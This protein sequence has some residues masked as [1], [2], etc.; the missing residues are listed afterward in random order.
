MITDSKPMH[1]IVQGVQCDQIVKGEKSW[2][3]LQYLVILKSVV[4]NNMFI[5]Q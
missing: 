5:I 4:K 1:V 3:Q 2:A